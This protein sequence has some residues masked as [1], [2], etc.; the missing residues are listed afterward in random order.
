MEPEFA[1]VSESNPDMTESPSQSE[2]THPHHNKWLVL[3]AAYK[4]LGALLFIAIGIG[5]LRLVGKD[6]DDVF[7]QLASDLHFN[8]EWRLVNFIL[9]EASLLNDPL[10]R[11][12][13][14]AAFGYAGLGILEAIG[15][16]LE[17]AWG[18]YL[19]LLITAS[20]LPLEILELV[21]RLTWA[22]IGLFAANVLV[23]LYLLR[24]V[25][26]R[27]ARKRHAQARAAE[28]D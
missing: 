4:L 21:R 13:G 6:I 3:I 23:L 11:R 20:F 8:P 22:R 2:A 5:A 15:L 26:E 1:A 19:T 14:L 24:I 18:E 28:Q 7:S 10:L 9:D 12:I 25:A 17:K 16:Y 27:T